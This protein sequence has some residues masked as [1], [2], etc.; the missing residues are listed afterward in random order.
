MNDI[1]NL[2]NNDR[3]SK[4][5]IILVTPDSAVADLKA[6][7]YYSMIGN[8]ML[9]SRLCSLQDDLAFI[10]L[11]YKTPQA[12]FVLWQNIIRTVGGAPTYIYLDYDSLKPAQV[13][14]IMRFFERACVA[15][16]PLMNPLHQI[17][18]VWRAEVLHNTFTISTDQGICPLLTPRMVEQAMVRA[19]RERDS[20]K[21]EDMEERIDDLE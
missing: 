17:K 9:R 3:H 14:I 21:S 11:K 12:T 8:Y 19:L 2:I 4:I 16:A 18:T 13:H 6:Q 1:P 10:D 15:V 20:E 7:S 5:Y